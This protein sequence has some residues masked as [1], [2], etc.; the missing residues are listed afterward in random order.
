MEINYC[1]FNERE[2]VDVAKALLAATD[3][4]VLSDVDIINKDVFIDYRSN[5][6]KI[7]KNP[8]MPVMFHSV[9]NPIWA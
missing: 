4:A 2:A 3:Y 6:R 8:V 9:P 5:L 1:P 7:M